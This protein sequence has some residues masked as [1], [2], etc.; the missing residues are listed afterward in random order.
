M[1]VLSTHLKCIPYYVQTDQVSEY[2]ECH[3]SSSSS[4]SIDNFHDQS[5]SP[6]VYL[7]KY[8][9]HQFRFLSTIQFADFHFDLLTNADITKFS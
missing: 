3:L 5:F 8:P 7:R 1:S 4:S 2:I 6:I 9:D